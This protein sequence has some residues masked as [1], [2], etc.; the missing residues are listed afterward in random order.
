MKRAQQSQPRFSFAGNEVRCLLP[1]GVNRSDPVAMRAA[2]IDIWL[3]IPQGDNK[4]N[5]AVVKMLET[6]SGPLSADWK[7]VLM[8]WPQ[9]QLRIM[10]RAIISL[11][12]EPDLSVSVDFR[13]GVKAQPRMDVKVSEAADTGHRR[14]T[15]YFH[16]PDWIP[17]QA[18]T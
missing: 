4:I 3:N 15:V 14:I 10:L 13:G 18:V 12:Y 2:C 8:Q 17:P 7:R 9:A 1:A 11:H 5:E 6:H 16:H